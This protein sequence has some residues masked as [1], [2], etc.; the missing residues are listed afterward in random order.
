M[1]HLERVEKWEGNS[2]EEKEEI[3]DIEWGAFGDNGVL[4]FFK[5][6]Y[7]FEVDRLSNHKGSFT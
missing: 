6:Q 4:D 7:D 5:T 1:E 2:K 3:I